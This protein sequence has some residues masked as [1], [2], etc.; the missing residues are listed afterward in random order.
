MSCQID[1]E[2]SIFIIIIFKPFFKL[3]CFYFCYKIRGCPKGGEGGPLCQ[4]SFIRNCAFSRLS[5][6]NRE[7]ISTVSKS[8]LNRVRTRLI[9]NVSFF[10][11][12]FYGF[13]L[14]RV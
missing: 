14:P 13:A 2:V 7:V 6:F 3:Y 12:N 5:F 9:H 8:K 10:F 1:A 11:D 4:V